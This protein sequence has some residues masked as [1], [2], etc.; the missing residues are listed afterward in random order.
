MNQK[1]NILFDYLKNTV[2]Q[3]KKEILNLLKHM[4]GYESDFFNLV[5]INQRNK[6]HNTAFK[7]NKLV[8]RFMG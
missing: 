4:N 5:K 2:K 8:K 7:S 3:K 6:I 1:V